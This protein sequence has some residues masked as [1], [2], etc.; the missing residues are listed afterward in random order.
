MASKPFRVG[1]AVTLCAAVVAVAIAGCGGSDDEPLT[2][3]EFVAQASS[4]CKRSDEEIVQRLSTYMR[5]QPNEGAGQTQDQLF[6]GAVDDVL[7]PAVETQIQAIGS[8]EP[9]PADEKPVSAYLGAMER[10]VEAVE[11]AGPTYTSLKASLY[12]FEKRFLPAGRIAG[13]YGLKNCQ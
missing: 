7:L 6:A 5:E 9:P 2:K 10:G 1:R 12:E 4:I 8:L 13:D 3:G 11:R